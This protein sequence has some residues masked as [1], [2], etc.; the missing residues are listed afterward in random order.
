MK[1]IIEVDALLDC[2]DCVR[3][4]IKVND[5]TYVPLELVKEFIRRFPKDTIMEA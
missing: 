5:I 3:G 4:D 1:Y 2:I